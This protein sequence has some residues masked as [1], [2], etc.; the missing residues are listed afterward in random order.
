M[1]L[2][3]DSREHHAV[4]EIDDIQNIQMQISP[5]P[6]PVLDP[7]SDGSHALEGPQPLVRKVPDRVGCM[8]AHDRVNVMTI[9]GVK[10]LS[11]KLHQVGG[12][13]LLR[14]R[15]ASIPLAV[16]GCG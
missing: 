9:P 4:A 1:T 10:R 6:K 2:F 13:G 3:P 15:P 7:A 5:R 12:R 16:V 14:H 11:H 8:E